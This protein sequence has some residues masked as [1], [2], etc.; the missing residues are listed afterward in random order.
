MK[1]GQ[2]SNS[3]RENYWIMKKKQQIN[4]DLIAHTLFIHKMLSITHLHMQECWWEGGGSLF[5]KRNSDI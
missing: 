2:I 3:I 5:E 4:K 1:I